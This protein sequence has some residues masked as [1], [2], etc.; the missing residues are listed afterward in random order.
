[1]DYEKIDYDKNETWEG[2]TKQYLPV[3][4]I[5][6]ELMNNEAYK[7]EMVCALQ[8]SEIMLVF[9]YENNLGKIYIFSRYELQNFFEN[10]GRE[11]N[12]QF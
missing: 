4:Y 5:N 1:M 11:N 8:F 12:K 3:F 6:K 10:Y 2:I 7:L 9:E